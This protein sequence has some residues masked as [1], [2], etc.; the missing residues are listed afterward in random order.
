[1]L[2]VGVVMLMRLGQSFP[3][4]PRWWIGGLLLSAM[5]IGVTLVAVL[6]IPRAAGT[7]VHHPDLLVPFG[8]LLLTQEALALLLKLPLLGAAFGASHSIKL[9][10][11][12][13]A[14]SLHWFTNLA[15]AAA[16]ATWVTAAIL[17]LRRTGQSD[18][19][20][21]LSAAGRRLPR[22]A[23]L[24]LLGWG[25]VFVLLALMGLAMPHLQWFAIL[26]GLLAVVA[27]NFVTAALLP[28]A[29]ILDGGFL[30][31][32]RAG[33]LASLANLRPWSALLLAQMLL[34]GL[35][36]FGYA[37]FRSG[38]SS[39]TNWSWSVNT[40]WTGGY[41]DN[42]HLYGNLTNT[43]KTQPV[44]LITALLT[45]LLGTLAVAVKLA[46]VQRLLPEPSP[47]GQPPILAEPPPV[48]LPSEPPPSPMPPIPPDAN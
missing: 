42:C 21:V 48:P 9:L 26:L 24:M 1:M 22:V 12:S 19:C 33:V 18:P 34:L 10:N 43:W 31:A 36:Y 40:F 44:P 7:L 2:G 45:L 8:L 35:F 28:V 38:N 16:Y 32:L 3:L 4:A 11:L 39:S 30:S 14:L 27:W 5:M 25:V 20:L 37:S 47:D 15:L 6:L 17:N 46:L 23:G 41:H 29:L 13:F